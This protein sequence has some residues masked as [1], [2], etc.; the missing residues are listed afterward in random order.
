MRQAAPATAAS[1]N[2]PNRRNRRSRRNRGN[3][4]SH[5]NLGS[6][7]NRAGYLDAALAP[8]V[9]LVEH[10]ERRQ[11]DIGDFFLAERDW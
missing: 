3:L 10:I 4:C 11:A 5:G 2:R 8:R 1:R 6:R 9:F 7:R